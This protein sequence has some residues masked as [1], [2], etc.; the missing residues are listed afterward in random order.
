MSLMLLL[1]SQFHDQP[2]LNHSHKLRELVSTM[3][4]DMKIIFVCVFIPNFEVSTAMHEINNLCALLLWFQPRFSE[5][6]KP[7]WFS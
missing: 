7:V 4:H 6:T 2:T 3:G 1:F 5:L